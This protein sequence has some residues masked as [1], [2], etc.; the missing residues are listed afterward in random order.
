MNA[1]L[2]ALAGNAALAEKL[3]LYFQR[4][5][6]WEAGRRTLGLLT[7]QD[8]ATQTEQFRSFHPLVRELQGIILDDPDTSSHHIVLGCSALQGAVLFLTHDGDSRMVYGDIEHFLSAA[9]QA[10]A[11]GE[12]LDEV[13]P[14]QA[15]VAADQPALRQLCQQL[16]DTPEAEEVLPALIPSLDLTDAQALSLLVR[17][18]DIY[19]PEAL[20]REIAARPAAHLMPV[21][22]RC[23][24][25]PHLMVQQAAARAK[26]VLSKR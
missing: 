12:M 17:D 23:E 5:A 20:C 19:V 18:E 14:D 21:V 24:K 26:N 15:W 10:C 16:L 1:G 13:A 4:I 3:S 11:A 9:R 7:Q 6:D 2:I 25:H 8:A 22:T